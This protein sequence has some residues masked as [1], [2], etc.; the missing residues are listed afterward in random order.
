MFFLSFPP[1]FPVVLWV[2]WPAGHGATWRWRLSDF[3]FTCHTSAVGNSCSL[4]LV[5]PCY[6]G[7]GWYRDYYLLKVVGWFWI[8]Q[9]A[10]AVVVIVIDGA[11]VPTAVS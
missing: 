7:G 9:A 4:V 6:I 5:P 2:G 1:Y 10:V 3:A 11:L 8:I